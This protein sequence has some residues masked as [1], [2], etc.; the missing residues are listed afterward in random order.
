MFIL[1]F[2]IWFSTSCQSQASDGEKVKSVQYEGMFDQVMKND[3]TLYVLNFWATW[4]VPCVRELPEFMAVNEKYAENPKFKMILVSLDF[5]RNKDALVI[6]FVDSNG[7]STEVLLLDD[8]KR[9]DQWI[10]MVDSSWSGALP[11]TVMYR[12]KKK[13]YFKEGTLTQNELENIIQN[14]L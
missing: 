2:L 13:V 5:A 3:N 4:C 11:A 8:A 12:N 14:Q 6:P 7:I 1:T 9:M 10:N